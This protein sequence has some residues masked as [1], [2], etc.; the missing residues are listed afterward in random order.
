[1]SNKY[2]LYHISIV[3]STFPARHLSRR[4]QHQSLDLAFHSL[5]HGGHVLRELAFLLA[6]VGEAISSVQ[7]FIYKHV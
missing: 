2:M 7:T 3:S 5:L 4:G 1:M 6:V